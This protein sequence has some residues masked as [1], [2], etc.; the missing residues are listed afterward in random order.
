MNNFYFILSFSRSG[1]TL[2]AKLLNNNKDLR[3]LNETWIFPIL[4]ILRWER[5][6]YNKQRYIL[7]I[8]NES[9]KIYKN[10]DLVSHNICEKRSI[11]FVSFYK[12]ILNHN[13]SITLEKNPVNALHFPYLKKNIENSK[14]IFLTRNPIA[15]ANSYKN[16][17]LKNEDYNYFLFRVTTVIRTYFLS[18]QKYY[19]EFSSFFIFVKFCLALTLFSGYIFSV[20]RSYTGISDLKSPNFLTDSVIEYSNFHLSDKDRAVI[21][22]PNKIKKFPIINFIHSDDVTSVTDQVLF[23]TVLQNYFLDHKA[24]NSLKARMSDKD[25]KILF[26][27]TIEND[28]DEKRLKNIILSYLSGVEELAFAVEDNVVLHKS[29]SEPKILHKGGYII[30]TAAAFIPAEEI[31][32]DDFHHALMHQLFLKNY[33]LLFFC[34]LHAI[35][36]EQGG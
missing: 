17:W 23:H 9:L 18:Y 11:S 31:Y 28:D 21:I 35:F 12:K 19:N 13:I 32:K 33:V 10:C 5:L 26:I 16:R 7:H 25:T 3:I 6:N 24:L 14:F 29:L 30:R 36:Q 4:S 20:F 27:Q 34:F 15:I 2:L 8:Y 1:S 22:S